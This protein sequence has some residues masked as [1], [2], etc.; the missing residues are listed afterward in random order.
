MSPKRQHKTKDAGK[1]RPL[2]DEAYLKHVFEELH[3]KIQI[4]CFVK[5]A[6]SRGP[7]VTRR[8]RMN[9]FLSEAPR[10]TTVSCQAHFEVMK[11]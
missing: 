7:R 1:S 8:R 11:S 6:F 3:G 4:H 5:A 2:S 9:V 10:V